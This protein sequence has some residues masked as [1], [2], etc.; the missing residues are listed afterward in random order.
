[1]P[2]ANKTVVVTLKYLIDQASIQAAIAG[3]NKVTGALT[4][5]QIT[6]EDVFTRAA[7]KGKSANEVLASALGRTISSAKDATDA[8]TNLE[9]A[10]SAANIAAKITAESLEKLNAAQKGAIAPSVPTNP[11]GTLGLP[12][13]GQIRGSG[14]GRLGQLARFGSLAGVVPG[15]NEAFGFLE[16]GGAAQALGVALPLLA[17]GFAVAAAAALTLKTN[18]DKLTTTA[19]AV[20]A[21]NEAFI[22][23]Q[24]GVIETLSKAPSTSDL[25]DALKDAQRAR[26]AIANEQAA[27]V[28][29][30]QGHFSDLSK[31]YGDLGARI[32]QA[33]VGAAS[34]A[35][36]T[37]SPEELVAE[38]QKELAAA[39]AGANT[40]VA[41]YTKALQDNAGAAG[42]AAERAKE[43]TDAL[44]K[45]F[46]GTSQDIQKQIDDLILKRDQ[47]QAALDVL[48]QQQTANLTSGAPTPGGPAPGAL[49][50]IDFAAQGKIL[51]SAIDGAKTALAGL[52]L[53]LNTDAT[54][55]ADDAK[56]L[57]DA[58]KAASDAYQ[59]AKTATT[60]Q[61]ND[62][63][64]G[65]KDQIDFI[66][67]E[68]AI[69]TQLHTDAADA[70]IH[71][72]E[73]EREHLKLQLDETEATRE[74]IG[75]HDADIRNLKAF[76]DATK[77]VSKGLADVTKAQQDLD[78]AE[79]DH[80]NQLDKLI[81]S[82]SDTE[83]KALN[84]QQYD[85][86]EAARKAG[87]DR[88]KAQAKADDDLLDKQKDFN[89]KRAKIERDYQRS[90]DQAIQDRDAVALDA[91]RTKRDDD[92][93]DLNTSFKDQKAAIKKALDAQNKTIDDS[94]AE[95]Q[96]TINHRYDEQI[97]AAEKAYADGLAIEAAKYNAE[98]SLRQQALNVAIQQYQRFL[99]T[100][101]GLGSY[102]NQNFTVGSDGKVH[103]QIVVPNVVN[104]PFLPPNANQQQARDAFYAYQR[105]QGIPGFAGG[106]LMRHEGLAWLHPGERVL[107]QQQTRV[108]DQ[109]S[110]VTV[111][112][113]GMGLRA[114]QVAEMVYREL[115]DYDT[116]LRN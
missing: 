10:V 30:T 1:M 8:Y 48:T 110:G 87:L 112:I 50:G 17:V 105:S 58:A 71:R 65:F 42:T 62:R 82:R 70:L 22:K 83:T 46:G 16:L 63:I 69:L 84:D 108:Y 19:K 18:L 66:G 40:E 89:D 28:T 4:V 27:L 34:G 44:L 79:N 107:T 95:Q 74:S 61:L 80:L 24:T 73:V 12:T 115:K 55:A 88:Q 26:Q 106:G 21:A 33:V 37:K 39:T 14:L 111:S 54:Q 93:K 52:G 67:A 3:T 23:S 41:L 53:T 60:E 2:P 11:V 85:L 43:F 68:N 92:L 7:A 13:G 86:S 90:A 94:L 91:A 20:E 47:A 100:L 36:G 81:K 96:R 57:D 32:V 15:G 45:G 5:N 38:R 99:E 77:E 98:I 75:L 64:G 49:S 102:Y 9:N 116:G 72:N 59:F 76:N 78:K 31:S 104:N 97:R 29:D 114:R 6:V 101:K 113:N 109:R 51:Q 35:T 56:S 103:G 25:E